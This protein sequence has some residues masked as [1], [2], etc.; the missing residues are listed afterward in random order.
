MDPD[1]L[2]TILNS[3]VALVVSVIALVYT[4]KT[5]WLKSGSSIRGQYTTTSSVACDDKY[6]SSVTIENLKDRST[7]VFEIYLRIGRNYYLRVE[8]FDPPLVLEPFSAFS[9][10]YGPVEFYSVGTESIDLNGMFDSRK[11]LPKLVLSTSEGKYV[12]KEWIR[13]WIPVADYFKNH[14]T[15]VIYPRRLNH[16]ERSY[17]SNTKFIVEFKSASG[18]EEIIPIYPRDYEIRKF[19]KFSLTKESLESKENLELYLL[20]KADEGILNCTNIVV[21]DVEE[22]RNEIYEDRKKEKVLA[23]DVSWFTYR[24]LGRLYTIYSDYKLR[25]ENRKIQ[26]QSAK[27]TKG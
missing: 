16:K 17:G 2:S 6:V 11:R 22:W 9:K 15:T 21:H 5:Y 24:I 27:N 4:I 14:L 10:E 23:T 19:R 1:K 3:T 20:E 13:R 8:E 26:K 25:R 12:V 18:K 7:V